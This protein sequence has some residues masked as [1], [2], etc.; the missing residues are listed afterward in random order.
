[1]KLIVI[2]PRVT[3]VAALA[4]MHLQVRPGEDSAVLAGIA[5]VMLTEGLYDAAFV[6]AETVGLA[7]LRAAVEPFTPAVVGARAGISADAVVQAARLFAAGRSGAVSAGTGANMAG[8]SNVTEYFVKVLT[9]LAGF[10]MRAGETIGNPGVMV[11]R[12]PPVA[13]SPGPFPATGY[14][15]KMRVRGL[16]ET[17]AGLPTAT[18]AEEM[19]MPGDGQVRALLVF[20]GNPMA[21]WPDQTK[22]HAAMQGLDLLVCF[23][24]VMS[25][26]ARLSH[27][28]IAPKLGLETAATT[29]HNEMFGNF[30]PGWGF[31]VPYA[32]YSEPV[33]APP[34]GS[35]LVEE[36]EAV[37]RISRHLGLQLRLRDWS[38][39]DPV[40]ALEGGTDVDMT[41][42]PSSD[43]VWHMITRHSPV[44]FDEV[45]RLG[46]PGHVFDRPMMVVQ[47]RPDDWAGRLDIGNPILLDEL[48]SVLHDDDTDDA[49]YPYRLI[50]RR[51]HDVVNSCWHAA[52]KIE[53][54]VAGNG[55]FLHPDD[56]LALGLEDGDAIDIA[57]P[58]ATIAAIVRKDASVRAGCVSMSHA[59]GGNPGEDDDPAVLGG[60]T[61]RLVPV[62]RDFDPFTGMPRMSAIPVR[63]SRHPG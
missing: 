29:M 13:A 55:A 3:E 5:R 53:P 14:G 16:E 62:D 54:R 4:D 6:D 44:P 15:H 30:G 40:A 26:T 24:P 9:T 50:S 12:A 17:P 11:N 27:Y 28:V 18:L 32:Q 35:D 46:Q 57:S 20:G 47:P 59:W 56:L 63:V 43:E 7:A 31:E 1:M 25:A 51:L 22:T 39:A 33:A 21:A 34:P 38:I 23:D 2:D 19:L 48:T 52:P 41:R 58:L 42:T 45:K 10:W 49:A 61:G 37:H 36:W 8:H 60:N